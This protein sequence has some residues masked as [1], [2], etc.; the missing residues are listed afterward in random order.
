MPP[1]VADQGDADTGHRRQ[2]RPGR[3]P[4][5]RGPGRDQ[6][7]Q[8]HQHPDDL[9][10][11]GD[12]GGQ[13]Q[14]EQDRDQ[15]DRHAAGFGDDGVHGGEGERPVH[16]TEARDRH[17]ADDQQEHQVLAA[18]GRDRAGQQDR[19]RLAREPRIERDEQNAQ[20]QAEGHDHADDR[21]SLADSNPQTADE[22]RREHRSRQQPQ[23][24]R[25]AQEDEARGTGESDFGQGVDGE[26]HVAG[27]D[28][29]ADQAGHDRNQDAGDQGVLNEVVAE[30]MD[31][32]VDHWWVP[33]GSGKW[34]GSS[35]SNPAP[36]ASPTTTMRPRDSQDLD[37]RVVQA[38]HRLGRQD[39]VGAAGGP[40]SVDDE[41]DSVGVAEDGVD[42][43]GHEDDRAALLRAPSRRSVR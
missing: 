35:M 4:L 28:E 3:Q 30:E 17:R 20:P 34:W 36:L 1:S 10:R 33:T 24:R 37:R 43:V 13:H 2:A 9:D 8:D 18:D 15:P 25:E 42:V 40:S 29:P 31:Q 27:H 21:V 7:R 39:L 12:R 16:H 26:G 38:G 41:D 6:E 22:D 23:N 19:E 14:Q 5:G 32:L 11:F